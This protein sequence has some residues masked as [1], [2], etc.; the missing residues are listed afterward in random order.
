MGK[1]V[2]EINY[3]HL[4]DRKGDVNRNWY[5]EFS[6]LNKLTGEKVRQ[7]IYEGFSDY[8]T[9]REKKAYAD[10]IIAEYKRKLDSGWRPWSDEPIE[11]DDLLTY[12]N[13]TRFK[14]VKT[15]KVSYIQPLFSDYLKWKK[16]FVAKTTI[17]DHTSKLRQFSQYLEANGILEKDLLY[18]DHEVIMTFLRVMAEDFAQRTIDKYKQVLYAFFSYLK[19]ERKIIIH[20]PLADDIP[21]LGKIVDMAPAGMDIDI[22]RMLKDEIEPEDPELWM[23]CCFIYYTTI[24]PGELRFLKLKQINIRSRSITVFNDIA[25]G[26]RTETIDIPDALHDLIVN[27]WQ[28]QNFGRELYL[29][30]RGGGPGTQPL[31]RN[32]MRYRFNKYRDRLGLPDEIQFYSWKHSGA[33]ELADLGASTYELQRHLRH[34]NL[35]TTEEYLKKRIGQRSKKIKRDFTPIS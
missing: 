30:G 19:K 31:G 18:Y 15:Q 11:F 4:N 7:R 5:V 23:A 24:R 8:K 35:S 16:P 17:E 9:Y 33:Q 13:A 32:T 1:K 22:R 34:K 29:F 2:K 21:R 25:K 6:V 12:Y 20:N 10:K 27:N 14:G 26:R 28:L 3:P